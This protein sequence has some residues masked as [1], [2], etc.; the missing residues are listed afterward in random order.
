MERDG[1]AASERENE[2]RLSDLQ[3]VCFQ[4]KS[5]TTAN[6]GRQAY[7]K[8]LEQLTSEYNR[9]Q[10][11]L[12]DARQALTQLRTVSTVASIQWLALIIAQD[13]DVV[14]LRYEEDKHNIAAWSHEKATLQDNW[15]RARRA[16]DEAVVRQAEYQSQNVELVQSN[17]DLVRQSRVLVII[18]LT[19]MQ[20]LALDESEASI[21]ALQQAKKSLEQNLHNFSNTQSENYH[22]RRGSSSSKLQCQPMM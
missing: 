15:A 20:R 9:Q 6:R 17:R 12:S 21:A 11:Q 14:T 22:L 8:E 19:S 1:H 13:Y 4:S 5:S 2:E 10:E 18:L 7:Q 3:K 16:F